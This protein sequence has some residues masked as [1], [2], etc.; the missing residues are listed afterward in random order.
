MTTASRPEPRQADLRAPV[1][2]SYLTPS[3]VA[4]LLQVSEKT[5]YRWSLQ[6]ASMPVMRLGRGRGVV[7]FNRERLLAWLARKEPRAS[8]ITQRSPREPDAAA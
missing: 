1:E 2:P 7:R 4:A 3:Q 6:D 8:R 5:I